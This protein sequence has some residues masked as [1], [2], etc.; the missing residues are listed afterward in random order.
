[1]I[2]ETV[3]W[4]ILLVA[5][6]GWVNRHQLEVIDYLREENRVLK[7]QLGGRRPR[8][9]DA[10]RRRLASRGHALG[11]SLLVQV[12][13]LVTP[14]TI[15]RWHRQLIASSRGNGLGPDA[16]SDGQASSTRSAS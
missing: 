1:M 6:A 10:Q 12:A 14:D 4:R 2:I 5:L 9:T 7:E 13:T 8:L 15:L 16:A 11:R 3:R